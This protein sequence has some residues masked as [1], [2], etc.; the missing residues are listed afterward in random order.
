MLKLFCLMPKCLMMIQWYNFENCVDLTFWILSNYSADRKGI[1]GI[2]FPPMSNVQKDSL[3]SYI[4]RMM[5]HT[6][7]HG[8]H[9]TSRVFLC[10]WARSHFYFVKMLLRKQEYVKYVMKSICSLQSSKYLLSVS[11][12][13]KLADLDSRTFR[14][15]L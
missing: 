9:L 15:G 8:L 10:I 7:A 13:K 2:Y 14:E 4:L 5:D 6:A 1:V 3:S 12:Q 11:L